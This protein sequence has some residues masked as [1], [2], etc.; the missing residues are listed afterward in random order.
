MKYIIRTNHQ[1]GCNYVCNTTTDIVPALNYAMEMTRN[2]EYPFP[3]IIE[4]EGHDEICIVVNGCCY[5]VSNP[6]QIIKDERNGNDET[7]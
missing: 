5:Q 1:D 2:G 7:A 6:E 4:T 3:L